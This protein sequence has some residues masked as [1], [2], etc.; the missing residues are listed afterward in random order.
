MLTNIS[1][2]NAVTAVVVEKVF[3]IAQHESAEE[4]KR[5]EKQRAH[6]LKSLKVLFMSID[7]DQNG[8]LDANEFRQVTRNL[9]SPL[10]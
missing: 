5:S 6:A 10:R 8:T 2:L 4:V 7:L 9:G 3:S 1:L